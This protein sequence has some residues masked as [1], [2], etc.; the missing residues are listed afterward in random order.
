VSDLGG[1]IRA[2]PMPDGPAAG[3][4]EREIASLPFPLTGIAGIP[5]NS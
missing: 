4:K 3:E 1:H 5:S 2:V